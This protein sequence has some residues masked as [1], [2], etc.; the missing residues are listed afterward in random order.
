MAIWNE[1]PNLYNNLICLKKNN[2]TKKI[3]N[4]YSEANEKI[5]DRAVIKSFTKYVF[6]YFWAI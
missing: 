3:S 2:L 6:K 5:S 1:F 4:I